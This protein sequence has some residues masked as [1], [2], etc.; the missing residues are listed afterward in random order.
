[1][2]AQPAT[3]Y[4]DVAD[5][6]QALIEDGTLRPGDR[7][8]SVRRL[9]GQWSV[10]ISTVLEAYRLLEDRGLI[11][12]RPRSGYFVRTSPLRVVE[13]PTATDPPPGPQQVRTDLMMRL[14]AEINEPEVVRLGAAAPDMDLL[15][16]RV[17]ARKVNHVMRRNPF[18]SHTYMAGPG[19]EGLRRQI[20]RR[21]VDAGCAVSPADVVVT[22]GA[23]RRSTS[24]CGR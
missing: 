3:L 24:P 11:E 13:E 14:H 1:M 19:D 17:L 9:H 8:P 6:V 16:G 21:M 7:I 22:A 20:A 2:T 4:E 10:S 18:A 12:A 15:P 23:R 5:R